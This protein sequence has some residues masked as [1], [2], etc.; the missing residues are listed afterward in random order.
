MALHFS[1]FVILLIIT[2]SFPLRVWL[3]VTASSLAYIEGIQNTSHIEN[4]IN[5]Y[6]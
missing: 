1:S 5:T 2:I 4:C 3:S 6:I